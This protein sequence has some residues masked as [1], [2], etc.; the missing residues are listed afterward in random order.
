M[1]TK[2]GLFY[3]H[4]RIWDKLTFGRTF[5][6]KNGELIIT[7]KHYRSVVKVASWRFFGTLDTIIIS[8]FWTGDYTKALAI[9][10]TEVVTKIALFWLHERIWLKIKWGK[11]VVVLENQM[12]KKSQLAT[13]PVTG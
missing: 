5:I 13:V 9:G 1:L 4:E 10:G 2:I 12:D 6:E 8:L 7:D 11:K 3:I